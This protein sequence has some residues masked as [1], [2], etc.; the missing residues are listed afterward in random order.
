MTWGD[1]GDAQA[2]Q[3]RADRA[4]DMRAV[5]VLV[6]IGRVVAG[7]SGLWRRAVDGGMSSVKLRLSAAS[8]FGAMSGCMPSMP[9]SMMPTSTRLLPRSFV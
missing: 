9:V 6:H 8:K 7:W 3:R 4:G 2:V 5:A 1:A